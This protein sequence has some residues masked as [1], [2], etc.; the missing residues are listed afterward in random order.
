[1]TLSQMS[2][3]EC[4]KAMVRITSSLKEICND[5]K[6][7]DA[8]KGMGVNGK[9][10]L[11]KFDA[12]FDLLPLLMTDHLEAILSIV[13]AMTGKPAN[14]VGDESMGELKADIQGFL[15]DEIVSF[16]T[17]FIKQAMNNET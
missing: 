6:V 14:A 4:A 5:S 10:L 8:I 12:L 1:M 7:V 15:D 9:T 2:V 3:R 13:S 17:S 16:F 11:D